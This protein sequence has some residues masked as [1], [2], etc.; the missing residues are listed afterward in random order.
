M[1]DRFGLV[2]FFMPDCRPGDRYGRLTVLDT[3]KKP[4]TYKY[5]AVCQCSCGSPPKAIRIDKLRG[6]KGKTESC[7]CFHKEKVTTHGNWDHPLYHVWNRMM[8]RCY[9]PK[10]KRFKHYGGR[11]ITVCPQWHDLN[12]FIGDMFQTYSPE[13]SIDRTDND[14]GYSPENCRWI[15]MEAQARNKSSNIEITFDGKTLCLAEW[16]RL[17]GMTYGT[18]WDR[19][20]VQGLPVEQ[21][22]TSPVLTTR[23]STD[24][25]RMIRWQKP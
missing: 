5:F 24:N 12:C 23:E 11:G 25:A 16:A 19:I 20:K 9:D 22:L 21:A 1:L 13:L 15:P 7:G 3:G 4:G 2:P 18:L 14:Q 10:D 8:Q 17:L 6:S